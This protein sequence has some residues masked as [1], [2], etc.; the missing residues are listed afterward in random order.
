MI[1]VSTEDKQEFAGYFERTVIE[2]DPQDQVQM[3]LVTDI[4]ISRWHLKRAITFETALIDVE[5]MRGQEAIAS[6]FA[7]IDPHIVA[8]LGFEKAAAKSAGLSLLG[9][10]RVQLRRTWEKALALLLSL[11]ANRVIASTPRVTQTLLKSFSPNEPGDVQPKKNQR[12][13]PQNVP[14]PAPA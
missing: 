8:A 11:K 7:T 1:C 2:L 4:V 6:E 3:D 13:W 9:R 10:Y 14:S 5:I 12:G